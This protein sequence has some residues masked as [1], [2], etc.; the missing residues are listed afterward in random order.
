MFQP[1]VE[2][3]DPAAR[4]ALQRERL[5]ALVGRLQASGSA[6]WARKLAGVRSGAE[7]ADHPFTVKAELRDSY[8]FGMLAVPLEDCIR[9]HASSGT[10]GKPTIVAYTRRDIDVFAEVNARAIACAGGR[11]QDVLQIAY[12]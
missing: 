12:G 5:G 11:P 3:M 7:L 2:A 9:I 8:P 6:F 1:E 10:H 4:S